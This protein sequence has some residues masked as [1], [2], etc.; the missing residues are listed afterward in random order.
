MAVKLSELTTES[1]PASNDILLIADPTTGVARKITVSALKT[2]M[3]GLGGGGD[4]TAPT[5]VSATASTASTIV[6]VFSES[7]T[8][9]TAGWSFKKNG[10]TWTVSSVSGSGATWTFTM[11]TSGVAGD[12]ILRSY[13]STT[14]STVDTSSN[15]LATFTD[16][17]VTNSIPGGYQTET[18]TFI[19]AV[20][21]GG[22]TLTTGQRDALDALVVSMK[23]I[24]WSK[25]QAAYPFV[26]S[27]AQ[28]HKWNLANPLDTDGGFR[29]TFTSMTHGASGITGNGTSSFMDT[30]FNPS[31]AS[32]ANNFHF[33]VS[34]SSGTANGRHGANSDTNANNVLIVPA[35][36]GNTDYF[37]CYGTGNDGQITA[38]NATVAG[39]YC[40][41]RRTGTDFEAYRDGTT[42]GTQTGSTG[43]ASPPN[44]NIYINAENSAGTAG[45]FGNHVVDFV[46]IGTGLTDSE[47]TS[48]TNAINTYNTALGR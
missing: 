20:Q 3:D 25:F 1:S 41:S 16:A 22:T 47:V 37:R 31:T 23:S 14:G 2:L 6:I 9:T 21:G 48:L 12:T 40:M 30:K 15:E 28:A 38:A 39:V 36:A 43:V 18:T 7:V 8:V 24:G 26:N 4:T 45:N 34:V 42:A 17:S 5:I 19:N 10:V 32:T 33:L 46:S 11:S 35:L 13:N 29:A 27:V 44:A